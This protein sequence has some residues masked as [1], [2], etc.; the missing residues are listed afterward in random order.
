MNSADVARRRDGAVTRERRACIVRITR[1]IA[2][3]PQP[4]CG[5]NV[6]R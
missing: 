4:G 5:L 2:A 3:N 6:M 1:P